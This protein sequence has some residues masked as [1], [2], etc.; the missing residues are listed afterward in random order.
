MRKA[1]RNFHAGKP[2]LP[3]NPNDSPYCEMFGADRNEGAER[4]EQENP[5]PA[6]D[7]S[8]TDQSG[9]EATGARAAI[10]FDK[11]RGE[12][13]SDFN[14]LLRRFTDICNAI[15]YA[16]DRG[17]L[18]RDLKPGNVMLG[19]HGETFV[20]DWGVAKLIDDTRPEDQQN[21]VDKVIVRA[22]VDATRRD[23]SPGTPLYMAPEQ[24]AG[25]NHRVDR[26]TDT[27]ALGLILCEILTGTQPFFSRIQTRY[28]NLPDHEK[29]FRI[30]PMLADAIRQGP[31]DLVRS[32]GSIPKP[33][34]AI[35]R[36]ALA[37]DQADRYQTARELADEV[38]RWLADEPVAAYR[39]EEGRIEKA[40]RWARRNRGK[41]AAIVAS[42]IF[43]TF[44]VIVVAS[45]LQVLTKQRFE[46]QRQSALA[47]QRAL[48][49]EK[50]IASTKAEKRYADSKAALKLAMSRGAWHEAIRTIDSLENEIRDSQ[51]SI[52]PGELVDLKL[53][54]LDAL[55]GASQNDEPRIMARSIE[56]ELKSHPERFDSRR[57]ARLYLRMGDLFREDQRPGET[58]AF[59]LAL[60]EDLTESERKYVIAQT[61]PDPKKAIA[62]L[63]E[64][65]RDD[66]YNLRAIVLVTTMKN[67]TGDAES[68]KERLRLARSIL[69]ED[70]V[71][72]LF[73]I[74][75]DVILEKKMPN[76]AESQRIRTA[77]GH[78]TG[79]AILDLWQGVCNS[80]SPNINS[81]IR[82]YASLKRIRD[83]PAG[84][85]LA[86]WLNAFTVN[87][88]AALVPFGKVVANQLSEP[89]LA[90]DFERPGKA[91]LE[92]TILRHLRRDF[93]VT[94]K[95]HAERVADYREALNRYPI[96]EIAMMLAIEHQMAGDLDGMAE[97]VGHM[98]TIR[99]AFRDRWTLM[100]TAMLMVITELDEEAFAWFGRGRYPFGP[101]GMVTESMRISLRKRLIS[102]LSENRS[103]DV[104]EI[105]LISQMASLIEE[106]E[107]ATLILSNQILIKPD[108]TKKA[109]LFLHRANVDPMGMIDY[110]VRP[111]GRIKGDL[112]SALR[113]RIHRDHPNL[114][115]SVPE[116]NDMPENPFQPS[117]VDHPIPFR[118][119]Y[120]DRKGPIIRAR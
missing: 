115:R 96:A 22:D 120:Y 90:F 65:L 46:T 6:E 11:L 3:K 18:H 26:R 111:S 107:L 60:K 109:F 28:D 42:L 45:L 72:H 30:K 106:H 38:N 31:P 92:M 77:F 20:I 39:G 71:L 16:H 82:M 98:I 56:Q 35:C 34:A 63:D 100:K 74:T 52:S 83:A 119:D 12:R 99:D 50:I 2:I 49:D 51:L 21:Q 57:R 58:S 25:D 41:A 73:A 93:K 19:N 103:F 64:S 87:P 29:R 105:E 80:V 15:D 44:G 118:F 114:A 86:N 113:I 47:A 48:L 8:A 78:D 97:A 61:E 10:R 69:P 91:L 67:L 40:A 85:R 95:N 23:I 66:P 17:V 76:E 24:L 9:P 36:K 43:T 7:V 81:T 110:L 116:L 5:L 102:M 14:D 79:Q 108:D 59:D 104:T 62:L 4:F 33:L 37:F 53:D 13:M 75:L 55:D 94:F 88:P 70:D 117:S 27:F 32:N 112:W 101:S 68:G 84:S 54:R 89:L 1:I